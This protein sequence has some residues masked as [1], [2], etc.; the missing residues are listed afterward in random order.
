MLT[1]NLKPKEINFYKYAPYI[2]LM[3]KSLLHLLFFPDEAACVCIIVLIYSCILIYQKPK[4]NGTQ[5]EDFE[6]ILNYIPLG[7]SVKIDKNNQW[8]YN[9][10]AL[11]EIIKPNNML[12]CLECLQEKVEQEA[13]G[14]YSFCGMRVELDSKMRNHQ[15]KQNLEISVKQ[16]IWKGQAAQLYIICDAIQLTKMD[17]LKIA[18]TIKTRILRSL[19]HELRTPINCILT[20]LEHCKKKLEC[21][22]ESLTN[23][24]IALA[25]SNFLLYKYND[26]LVNTLI[27]LWL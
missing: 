1:P 25:N 22:E 3:G 6:Q 18:N 8:V 7:I 23:I 11:N 26:L 14:N 13:K 19:S 2:I 9:N 12:Q 20:S 5:L 4:K 17:H 21:D 24:N 16:I 15:G 27:L 10:T